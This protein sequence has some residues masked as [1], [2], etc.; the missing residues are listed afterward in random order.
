MVSTAI[1]IA[2]DITFE[3]IEPF[4][5]TDNTFTDIALENSSG[6]SQFKYK[7]GANGD[8]SCCSFVVP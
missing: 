4:V 8:L 7:I 3:Q 2:N 6:L 1:E 5:G